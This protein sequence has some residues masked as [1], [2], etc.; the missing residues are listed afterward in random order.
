[1]PGRQGPYAQYVVGISL[2]KQYNNSMVVT[3][4]KAVLVSI[5]WRR[6]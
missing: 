6:M 4:G 3:G 1:M 2:E 5:G